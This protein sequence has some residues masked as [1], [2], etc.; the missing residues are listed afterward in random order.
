M[1]KMDDEDSIEKEARQLW[2]DCAVAYFSAR[3]CL[4]VSMSTLA[5]HLDKLKDE[6][7]KRFDGDL[8]K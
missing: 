3:P 1:T 8:K 5:R 6:F 4:D 2:K 7:I